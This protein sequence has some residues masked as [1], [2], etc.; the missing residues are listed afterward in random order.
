MLY[1]DTSILVAYYSPE[2]AIAFNKKILDCIIGRNSLC[3]V[4]VI[5]LR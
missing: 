2:E 3:G 1:L 5:R 4:L